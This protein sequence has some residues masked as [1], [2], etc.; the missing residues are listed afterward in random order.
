MKWQN[1]HQSTIHDEMLP[2]RLSA[3]AK[4]RILRA[5]RRNKGLV[6]AALLTLGAGLTAVALPENDRPT[7]NA[8]PLTMEVHGKT[9]SK[10]LR[11]GSSAGMAKPEAKARELNPQPAP[12]APAAPTSE[13]SK[14]LEAFFA[15]HQVRNASILK[16]RGDLNLVAQ[17]E[18][19]VNLDTMY[20]E[21]DAL[22]SA[23]QQVRFSMKDGAS[24]GSF[25]LIARAN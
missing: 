12:I 7:H 22:L 13:A 4:H 18:S 9:S 17:G 16:S 10:D 8:E 11:D 15:K 21:A 5:H 23:F 19:S 2:A 3:G 6:A 25:L 1:S 20:A 24:A 14:A